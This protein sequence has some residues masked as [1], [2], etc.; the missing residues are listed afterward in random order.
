[1]TRDVFEKNLLEGQTFDQYI[2]E[3]SI[4]D[5]D[6][7]NY[8]KFKLNI[9]IFI[10]TLEKEL[11]NTISPFKKSKIKKML[12]LFY[13]LKESFCDSGLE[14]NALELPDEIGFNLYFENV[15]EKELLP[16]KNALIRLYHYTKMEGLTPQKTLSRITELDYGRLLKQYDPKT[17]DYWATIHKEEANLI[18]NNDV[19]NYF[20]EIPANQSTKESHIR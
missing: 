16:Q 12:E 11:N 19:V 8:Y 6:I 9:Q 10:D 14:F 3:D 15:P 1:M 4:I 5:Y 13:K 7:V 17:Y 18:D 2:A 20:E